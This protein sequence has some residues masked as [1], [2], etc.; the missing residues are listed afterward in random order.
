MIAV[1]TNVLVRLLA[2]DDPKQTPIARALFSSNDIWIARTVLLETNWVLQAAFGLDEADI[3]VA[4]RRLFGLSNVHVEQARTV[5]AALDLF[6]Q[7]ISFADA[8]HL[9][10]R[11]AGIPFFSF[12]KKFVNRAKRAGVPDVLAKLD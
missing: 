10:S 2:E 1:D 3:N 8:L 11:P 7:G 12:D 4:F 5:T 6:A 9:V